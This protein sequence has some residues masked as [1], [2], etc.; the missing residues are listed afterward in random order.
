MYGL[1]NKITPNCEDDGSTACD[2]IFYLIIINFI[3]WAATI[4]TIIIGVK[5]QSENS[6]DPDVEQ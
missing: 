4:M 2:T 6:T 1:V 5:L 3:T